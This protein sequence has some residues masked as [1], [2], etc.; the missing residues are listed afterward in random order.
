MSPHWDDTTGASG[1]APAGRLLP[2]GADRVYLAVLEAGGLPVAE[3]AAALDDDADTAAR[4]VD[5]LVEMGLLVADGDT[6]RPGD[7]R[8]VEATYGGAWRARAVELLRRA[9]A[10]GGA[11]EPLTTAYRRAAQADPMAPVEYVEGLLEINERI[12][13]AL[14]E[15]ETELLTAQPGGGRSTEVLASAVERDLATLCLAVCW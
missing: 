1:R 3:A 9:T 13:E 7:P 5:D 8:L 6:V 15:C 2:E 14:A 4:V 12:D 10:L 11:L